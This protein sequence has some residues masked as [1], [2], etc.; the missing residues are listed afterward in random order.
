MNFLLKTIPLLLLLG[1]PLSGNAQILNADQFASK[2]DSSQSFKALFD[3]SMNIRRPKTLVLSIST[4]LDMSY[5]YKKSLFILKG[6]FSFFRSGSNDF[7]NSGFAHLRVRLF[8]DFWVHPEFFG[9]YQ[10]D[11]IRG[12]PNRILGGGNLRF[13]VV[14]QENTKLYLGLG[15]MYEYENWTYDGVPSSVVVIDDTPIHNHYTKI[16]SYA[17]FYQK[18][19]DFAFFQMIVYFQ[20]R[21]DA[22][23][24]LPRASVQGILGFDISKHF[25]FSVHYNLTYDAA[26]PVPVTNWYYS[27]VNKI[28]FVW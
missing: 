16:N 8:S 12:M 7:L 3:F 2:V 1:L 22:F 28:S 19:K 21:P 27:I 4:G 18:I 9:Q 14:E 10:T 15:Y 26:P 5:W 25:R 13:R 6:K 24:V 20:A 17:S 23:F 11:W